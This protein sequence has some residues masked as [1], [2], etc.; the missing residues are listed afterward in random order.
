MNLIARCPTCGTTFRVQ[1]GQLAAKGGKVRCGKC[2]AVF[3]GVSAL[4]DAEAARR[5][6]EEADARSDDAPVDDSAPEFLRPARVQRFGFLWGFLALLGL[7]AFLGQLL[8]HFRT[9]IATQWPDAKPYLAQAC[10]LLGCELRL[11][12]RP[13]QMSIESSDIQ[14]DPARA[15]VVVLNTVVR[16]RAPFAQDYPALEVTLTDERDY[17][18][19]RRVLLPS[20]YLRFGGA[21][22][23]PQG[24]AGGSEA[25]VR[26][27]L[28]HAGPRAVGYRVYL[29]YP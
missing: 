3:D 1:P 22:R 28:E 4:V 10:E 19:A 2:A 12:R 18:V 7:A 27:Y 29:F 25:V 17:A 6:A 5:L 24:L 9:E 16:N 15:N 26:V 21:E 20:D 13:D 11:P 23:I 8:L 14:P